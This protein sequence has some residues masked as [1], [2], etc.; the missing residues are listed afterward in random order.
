MM[1][2][3]VKVPVNATGGTRFFSEYGKALSSVRASGAYCTSRRT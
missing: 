2:L 1:H 3:S